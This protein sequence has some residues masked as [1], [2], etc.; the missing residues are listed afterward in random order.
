[1]AVAWLLCE[2]FI[3]YR[4]KTLNYL[5]Y[6]KIENWTFNKGIQKMLES[7]RVSDNDKIMLRGLKRVK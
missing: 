7:Y 3:K 5:Y 1:M 4:D 2:C 6:S